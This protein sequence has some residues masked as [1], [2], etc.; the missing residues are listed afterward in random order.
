MICWSWQAHS[1]ELIVLISYHCIFLSGV[2]KEEEEE[3]TEDERRKRRKERRRGEEKGVFEREEKKKEDREVYE[4][5]E[6][7]LFTE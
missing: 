2:L 1:A 4:G 7:H 3:E 5:K 6:R